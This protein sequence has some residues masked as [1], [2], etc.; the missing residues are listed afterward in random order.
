MARRI[1][2]IK[3]DQ[4]DLKG[5]KA[6]PVLIRGRAYTPPEEYEEL[7]DE[8][9]NRIYN[10]LRKEHFESIKES[11]D[12]NQFFTNLAKISSNPKDHPLQNLSRKDADKIFSKYLEE[13][14]WVNTWKMPEERRDY[15]RS[16][17]EDEKFGELGRIKGIKVY[18]HR[19]KIISG[20][21]K[22]PIQKARTIW[23]ARKEQR[24]YWSRERAG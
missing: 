17:I 15:Y 13:I 18:W 2:R 7:S 8:A 9:I 1:I 11:F 21:L 12:E 24:E 3:E 23:K 6:E 14:G 20:R 5:K 4:K 19:V 16:L 22:I 10:H